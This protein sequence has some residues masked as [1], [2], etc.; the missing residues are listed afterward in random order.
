VSPKPQAHRRIRVRSDPRPEAF[1]KII[2]ADSGRLVT[3]VELLSPS[4]KLSGEGR[5]QYQKKQRELFDAGVSLV[6]IDLLRAGPRVFLLPELSIPLELRTEYAACVF[7][8]WRRDQFEFYPIRLRDRLPNIAIPLR[9]TDNQIMLDLQTLVEQ[10]YRNGRH[11]R[12]DYRQ[13]CIPPLEA[14]DSEWA[15]G[16]VQA[17]GR[18]GV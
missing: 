16:L 10:A 8:G 17:A 7:R 5:R 2:E 1:V 6:E 15:A 12:T 14:N 9:E 13:P 18:G 3:V 4:N 11:D